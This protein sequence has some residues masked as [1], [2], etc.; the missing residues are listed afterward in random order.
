MVVIVKPDDIRIGNRKRVLSAV[1][2]G[3]G[4]SRTDIGK[5]T[6]LSAATISAITSDFLHEGILMP[7][8]QQE[9]G[10]PGRGRPKV[11]LVVNPDAAMVCSVNFQLNFL[12]AAMVDYSGATVSE[13]TVQITA[14]ENTARGIRTALIDCIEIALSRS[15][16]G[17]SALRRIAIGFQGVTDVDG[18]KVLW[19]PICSDRNIPVQRWLEDRFG[20]PTR[21][22]N[23]CDMI[24]QALNWRDPDK[25]GENFAA[26]LLAHGVGM[27]LFLRRTIVNGTQSS[28]IEFGHMTYVPGGALCR[29]GNYGCIEA[30]AG[31]Y[32]ISRRAEGH[33]ENTPPAGLLDPPDLDAIGEAARA[34]DDNAIKAIETAGAAIG[35]GLASLYAL[36]DAFPVVLVGPGANMFDLMEVPIRAALDCAPGGNRYQRVD[37]D[38][39]PDERPLVREG[40]AISAL[41]V[42]DDVMAERRVHSEVSN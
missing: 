40:C 11:A 28:G 17:Q 19:S 23:D 10:T 9:T 20:V 1:R 29:C 18:T 33:A 39:Y 30:Y 3:S 7:P 6:G 24:A 22:A 21:V 14:Q 25:Y 31:N 36:V 16:R 8:L 13:H 4:A 41:L 15:G 27:G 26:V 12:S 42:Q 35:T 5:I 38:C 2:R 32:A 34:G 37:I